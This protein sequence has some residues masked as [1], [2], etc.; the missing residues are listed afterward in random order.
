MI[1][2]DVASKKVYWTGLHANAQLIQDYR[3]ASK[4]N[5][6]SFTIHFDVKK[7]FP[8]TFD[9]F[10]REMYRSSQEI[11]LRTAAGISEQDY[12][13]HM[14]HVHDIDAEMYHL[15]EK[16]EV[17]KV[18]KL[19]RLLD[20]NE[21]DVADSFI[22]EILKNPESSG[23]LKFSAITSREPIFIRRYQVQRKNG[24]PA[25]KPIKFSYAQAMELQKLKPEV[26]ASLRH[27]ADGYLL[28]AEISLLADRDTELYHNWATNTEP[29]ENGKPVGDPLWIQALIPQRNVVAREL[30]KKIGEAAQL[31]NTIAEKKI[32]NIA[33]SV[34]LKILSGMPFFIHRLRGE[35][36]MIAA[37][38]YEKWY[39]SVLGLAEFVLDKIGDASIT[40]MYYV[41][42]AGARV[43]LIRSKDGAKTVQEYVERVLGKISDADLRTHELKKISELIEEISAIE[44]RFNPEKPEWS[45]FQDAMKE[46]ARQVLNIEVDAEATGGRMDR[47]LHAIIRHGIED[48]NPTA[49]MKYCKHLH[50]ELSGGIGIPA[51]AIGLFTARMKTVVCLRH[52]EFGMR[53]SLSLRQ[54]IESFKNE[55]CKMPTGFS[56]FLGIKSG[57]KS[58]DK[59]LR[60]SAKRITTRYALGFIIF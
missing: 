36:L 17:T 48:L 11:A 8:E 45:I 59:C 20:G 6:D 12:L 15:K 2:C 60:R 44:E 58:S 54:T 55:H 31:L 29:G 19:Q 40:D 23:R 22:A 27:M 57:S 46:Q 18:E 52:L 56:T 13:K 10:L 43:M 39:I 25:I 21:I 53:G 35:G 42:L 4:K 26:G 49:W 32:L 41:K 50:F 38:H 51:Q 16:Y 34:A 5:Q 47:T 24:H 9:D 7:T 3:E 14:E 30:V 37:L 28:G 33:P 1:L